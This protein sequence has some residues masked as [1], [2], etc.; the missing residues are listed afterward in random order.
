MSGIANL[1]RGIRL[2]R[3]A[4]IVRVLGE[5]GKKQAEF[6]SVRASAPGVRVSDSVVL[7][8]Y[9]PELLAVSAGVQIREGSIL[10]FGDEGNGYGRIEIGERSWIGQYNNLRAGGGDIRIGKGCLV[11]QFCSIVA[12]NHAHAV[13]MPIQSQ[14]SDQN[15]RGVWIG[16][17]VWLGAGSAVMPGVR[18]ADGA[19]VGANAVVT[20]DIPANEIWAGIP[21][22]K[23]G[24][25]E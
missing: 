14:G 23:I 6:E 19:I 15:R 9:R 10:A 20:S 17:D 3:H 24:V 2:L 16:D 8:G 25:R 5:I 4:Q 12:S 1:L 11:S 18:I 7:I 22:R 21:A 13:D